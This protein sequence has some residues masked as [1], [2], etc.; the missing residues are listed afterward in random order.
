MKILHLVSNRWNSAICEYAVSTVHCCKELGHENFII[1]LINRPFL[2]KA[3]EFCDDYKGFSSFN[4]WKILELKNIF[5]KFKPDIIFTYGGPE[6]FLAQICK[7][8]TT[9][10]FRFR[11]DVKSKRLKIYLAECFFPSQFAKNHFAVRGPII[12]LGIDEKKFCHQKENTKEKTLEKATVLIFGRF[13]PVKGHK[14]FMGLFKKIKNCYQ[15]E[16]TLKIVGLEANIK[17]EDLRIC[18][19]D[20]ELDLNHTIE[21]NVKKV[22]DVPKLMREATVGVIC[23]LDSEVIC[24]VA[25]EFLLCGTPILVSDAGSL[26]EVLIEPSFGKVYSNLQ[27]SEIASLIA[28]FCSESP[29]TR[30]NRAEKARKHF[31]LNAMSESLDREFFSVQPPAV[32]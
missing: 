12:P 9:K 7:H 13:D 20:S 26:P 27:P 8:K 17:A 10:H 2:F 19:M 21:I 4:I 1:G 11:G 31:S 3:H 29:I 16:I 32:V 15:G 18:A 28:K 6:E 23:S 5:L 24:R 22:S 25:E 30:K 14:E